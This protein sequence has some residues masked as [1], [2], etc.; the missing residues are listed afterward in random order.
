MYVWCVAIYSILTMRKRARVI[1]CVFAY[2]IMKSENGMHFSNVLILE[3]R[4]NHRRNVCLTL[5]N[6]WMSYI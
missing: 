6:K 1:V 5:F 3:Q 4:T 2:A